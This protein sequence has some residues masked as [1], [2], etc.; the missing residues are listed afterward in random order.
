ML[1]V[2]RLLLL[3]SLM[4]W[5]GGFFFYSAVV[6]EVGTRIYGQFG[7]GLITRQVAFWLNLAGLGAL[8]LWIWDLVA[9][10]STRVKRRW[11][12]WCVMFIALAILAFL[13]PQMDALM[14]LE[15]DRLFNRGDFR[16]MHR[17]YLWISTAQWVAAIVFTFWTL[18]NWRATDANSLDRQRACA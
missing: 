8:I 16:T 12:A 17:W 2:R 4:F 6:V 11:F 7:Q 13:H 10:R 18:Q 5:Q 15:H 1:I 9:E 3:W 14:D